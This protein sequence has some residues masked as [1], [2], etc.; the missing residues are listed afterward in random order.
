MKRT[1][2]ICL[3][4]CLT[5]LAARPAQAQTETVLYN[6]CS[7]GNPCPDGSNPWSLIP[8]GKGNFYGTT[9]LGG[10]PLGYGT[11]FEL[12]PNGS[13]GWNE[14]VL[15]SFTGG[16]DGIFPYCTLLIDSAGNI[17]GSTQDGGSDDAG[18][19]FELSS[20]QGGWTETILLNFTGSGGGIFTIDTAGNL[21]GVAAAGDGENLFELSPSG[22][23]W[24]EQVIYSVNNYFGISS[25]LILDTAGNIFLITTDEEVSSL[26]ELSP[27]GVGSWTP[28]VVYNF[29]TSVAAGALV[30][31]GAGNLYFTTPL[32]GT[33][34]RGTVYKLIPGDAGWTAEILHSFQGGKDGNRPVGIV[35]DAAG[36]IYGTTAHGGLRNFGTV[37]ELAP[38]TLKHGK[39]KKRVLWVFDGSDGE[40]PTSGPILDSA[41]NLY[42]T[43]GGGGGGQSQGVVFEV[44]PP[45]CWTTT[46]L[47][48]SL[49][50]SVYGQ[51]VTFTAVVSCS[52]GAP[53]NGESVTFMEGTKVLGTG[54]LSSGSATFTTSTLPV[55]TNSITAAYGG[56]GK[57]GGSTS[58][59]VKQVVEEA[60]RVAP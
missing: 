45:A 48:S 28:T 16:A 4:L 55:G 20:S 42:G 26:V 15:H 19:V 27:N 14:T 32:G 57:F 7:G 23:G 49:N 37:F 39:Y 44:T 6:F 50:P 54:S 3:F 47:R 8:D 31:D 1:Y 52:L 56:D 41:G 11:V 59:A 9:I 25:G 17:Y 53:P 35:L 36:N 18:V 30:F 5:T 10:V 43:T 58:N 24:T 22:G 34:N 13:G 40:S 2:F 29:G 46:T 51:P 21:Y 33:R 12:S 38:P 60:A